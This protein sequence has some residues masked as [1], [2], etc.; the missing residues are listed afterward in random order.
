MGSMAA[1][2]SLNRV[3]ERHG[4]DL[5]R[6]A[7]LAPSGTVLTYRG[8]SLETRTYEIVAVHEFENSHGETVYLV[9]EPLDI[10][11]LAERYPDCD[12]GY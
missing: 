10:D 9:G 5:A 1:M 12:V 8:V 2:S 3:L 6:E 7:Q 11:T 4:D